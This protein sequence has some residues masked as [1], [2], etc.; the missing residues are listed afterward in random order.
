MLYVGDK[1]LSRNSKSS[2]LATLTK[3]VD[4]TY[5]G[6]PSGKE[7]WICYCIDQV[8]KT[9]DKHQCASPKFHKTLSD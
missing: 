6:G 3:S 1:N 5:M 7:D 4:H 2:K 8:T 9:S